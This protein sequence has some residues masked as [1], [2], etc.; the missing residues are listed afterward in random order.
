MLHAHLDAN[1]RERNAKAHG[2]SRDVRA[3]CVQECRSPEQRRVEDILPVGSID[4]GSAAARSTLCH[5]QKRAW[6]VW[7]PGGHVGPEQG[8]H[9]KM[10]LQLSC[11]ECRVELAVHPAIEI[12]ESPN[13]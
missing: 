12:I 5:L 8:M 11:S 3:I 6:Q 7:E 9:D 4:G 1:A 10:A 2:P 13:R